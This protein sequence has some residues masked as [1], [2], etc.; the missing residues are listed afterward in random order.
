MTYDFLSPH[1]ASPF[2]GATPI[3]RSPIEHELVRAG[4]SFQ[5]TDGWNVAT[6]FASPASELQAARHTVAISDRSSLAKFE[7][8]APAAQL[9]ELATRYAGGPPALGH[10]RE[11]EGAWLCPITRQRLLV[12]AEPA[13]GAALRR[14]LEQCAGELAFASVVDLT[15]GLAAILVLGPRARDLLA[16]L[17]ALDL[18]PQ[19]APVG[20]VR[21]GSVA[22]VPAIVLHEHDSRFL[23]LFGAAQAQYMWTVIADAGRPLDAAFVGTDLVARLDDADTSGSEHA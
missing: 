10:A 1:A 3:A 21:P 16:T 6:A 2:A 23:V 11:H 20:A 18:R 13:H 14:R 5:V 17:T 4:A 15:V 19:A 22:R 12:L 8:Q 7:L 9:D